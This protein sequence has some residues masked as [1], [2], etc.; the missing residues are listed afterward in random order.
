M[1]ATDC[2]NVSTTLQGDGG[3][4]P[5]SALSQPVNAKYIARTTS[6]VPMIDSSTRKPFA[7]SRKGS[8]F[9]TWLLPVCLEAIGRSHQCNSILLTFDALVG[10]ENFTME[11]KLAIGNVLAGL[12]VSCVSESGPK[13]CAIVPGAGLQLNPCLSLSE[14]TTIICKDNGTMKTRLKYVTKAL[15]AVCTESRPNVFR[16]TLIVFV[17]L[18]HK[19]SR[20]EEGPSQSPITKQDEDECCTLWSFYLSVGI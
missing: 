10:R 1:D 17:S 9:P 14:R 18:S 12:H 4:K 16:K 7:L 19:K 8:I 20:S 3:C 6:E 2:E 11:A 15:P 5:R 13:H